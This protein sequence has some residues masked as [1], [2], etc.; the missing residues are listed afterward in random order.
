MGGDAGNI[1]ARAN[2]VVLE[3]RTLWH[4]PSLRV[5]KL[6]TLLT[7]VAEGNLLGRPPHGLFIL[8]DEH[9][10][11]SHR[12][13]RSLPLIRALGVPR[14]TFANG[15]RG[16]DLVPDSWCRVADDTTPDSLVDSFPLCHLLSQ[17]IENASDERTSTPSSKQT[18]TV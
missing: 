16:L 1:A 11:R 4:H 8:I 15:W 3:L 7:V 6:D 18:S 9:V 17:A 5:I 2:S 14:F 13:L 12:Q 10:G